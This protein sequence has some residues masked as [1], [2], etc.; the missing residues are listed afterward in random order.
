MAKKANTNTNAYFLSKAASALFTNFYKTT[1]T[2]SQFLQIE[3]DNSKALIINIKN[4]FAMLYFRGDIGTGQ[5]L[6]F[7][8]LDSDCKVLDPLRPLETLGKTYYSD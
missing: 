3:I 4:I 5:Y 2:K 1:L 6:W 8:V 7:M